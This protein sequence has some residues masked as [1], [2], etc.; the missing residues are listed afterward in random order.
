[1]TEGIIVNKIKIFPMKVLCI[2]NDDGKYDVVVNHQYFCF[3]LDDSYIIYNDSFSALNDNYK[4]YSVTADVKGQ[5]N[6]ILICP[7]TKR[8][9]PKRLFK[10]IDKIREEKLN[11]L[12]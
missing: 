8:I 9:Y 11:Q 10:T 6:I 5:E 12:L 1:M 4:T 7:F 2:S 3:T